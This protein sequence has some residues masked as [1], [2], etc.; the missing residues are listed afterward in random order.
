MQYIYLHG[1]ASSA[2]S[3]KA[4]YFRDRFAEQNQN[5]EIL[6]FNQ[7]GFT[8]LTLS[9]QIQQTVERFTDAHTSVTLI[10]SSFGGLTAVWVAA[11]RPL[12]ER[13]VLMAPAFGFPQSW[14]DRLGADALQQWQQTQYL[15]IYHYGDR[16]EQQLHYNFFIDAQQ[17]EFAQIHCEQPTLILHGRGDE[18]VP[19]ARS[20]DYAANNPQ[21]Q[22]IELESDHSLNDQLPEMWRLMAMFLQFSRRGSDRIGHS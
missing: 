9:R 13:L 15:P 5:L 11:Q 20:Q 7:G 22:L 17:Y 19:I 12:V 1:F 3:R 4:Q 2:Q 8:H 10:G 21:A 6:D 14:V 18:V 16:Q